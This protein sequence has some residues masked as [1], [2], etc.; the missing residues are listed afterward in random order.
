MHAP[1]PISKSVFDAGQKLAAAS[2]TS[3]T[4]ALN[5]ALSQF[6]GWPFQV[7]SGFV[8]DAEGKK[9]DGFGTLIFTTSQANSVA[10]PLNIDS[11][12]VGCV[13]DASENMDVEQLAAAYERIACAKRLKKSPAPRMPGIPTPPSP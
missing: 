9:T 10:E 12:S 4:Q 5:Q 13:I 11:N 8:S 6:L 3:L 1:V 2:P 7:A